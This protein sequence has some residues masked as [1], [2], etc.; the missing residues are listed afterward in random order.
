MESLMWVWLLEGVALAAVLWGLVV[1]IRGEPE[2][3]R[4]PARPVT[5]HVSESRPASNSNAVAE[6]NAA[7]IPAEPEED[8]PSASLARNAQVSLSKA[9]DRA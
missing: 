9:A 5:P 4:P 7:S 3:T 6:H 1:L 2:T 8:S